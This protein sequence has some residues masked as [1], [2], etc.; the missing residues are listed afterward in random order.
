MGMVQRAWKKGVHALS[1]FDLHLVV[2]MVRFVIMNIMMI[3]MMMRYD[4]NV[5]VRHAN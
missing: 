1:N 5:D 2:L 3:M 4:L